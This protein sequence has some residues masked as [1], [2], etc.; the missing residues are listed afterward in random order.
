MVS[1][2]PRSFT[3]LS[4]WFRSRGWLG[5]RLAGTSPHFPSATSITHRRQP[6]SDEVWSPEDALRRAILWA[7]ELGADHVGVET[8]QGGDT[9]RSTYEKV[10]ADLVA[11]GAIER[12]QVPAF[13]QAKA[14]AGHGPKTHRASQML[15]DYERGAFVHVEGTH[16]VLERAL[17]RF[18]RTKPFDLV[19]ASYWSWRDLH[20]PAARL[21]EAFSRAHARPVR[22]WSAPARKPWGMA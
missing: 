4:G 18:P 11:E 10:A 1:G 7:V 6:L 12:G 19:D 14:G 21:G 2:G 16:G 8:D 5:A 15:T 20:D 9:W 17:R 13:R 22:S 3:L